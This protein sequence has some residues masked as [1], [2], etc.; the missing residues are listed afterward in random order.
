MSRLKCKCVISCIFPRSTE[1]YNICSTLTV[2]VQSEN[3]ANTQKV[4]T[5]ACRHTVT[6]CYLATSVTTISRAQYII[7]AIN[8]KGILY[9]LFF[10]LESGSQEKFFTRNQ[11]VIL[12][13]SAVGIFLI[14]VVA[15][16]LYF[17][18][19]KVLLRQKK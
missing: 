19:K 10:F 9:L 8:T 14:V 11:E 5:S 15:V 17:F 1:V 13:A 3:S 12:S 6:S 16:A 7:V 4:V 2:F 18:R